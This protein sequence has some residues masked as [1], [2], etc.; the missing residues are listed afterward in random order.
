M[1]KSILLLFTILL[2]SVSQIVF[3]EEE[4]E[5]ERGLAEPKKEKQSI[6]KKKSPKK[7]N[8]KS[9]NNDVDSKKYEELSEKEK[10]Q[11]VFKKL[12]EGL[13]EDQEKVD[14]L[15]SDFFDRNFFMEED[16]PF[17]A[18]EEIR[19]KLLDSFEGQ[20]PFKNGFSKSYDDWFK[21]QFGDAEDLQIKKREDSKAVYFDIDL[22][23]LDKKSLEVK[24]ESGMVRISGTRVIKKESK[25]ASGSSSSITKSTF[26]RSF[27]VPDKVDES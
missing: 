2:F 9:K 19:K 1:S 25:S 8:D 7:S 15:M 4:F 22:S 14:E 13:K 17:R 21:G 5:L 12:Y 24:V 18:M 3:A 20:D 6:S 10:A 16:D 23:N 26:V 11:R 27:P